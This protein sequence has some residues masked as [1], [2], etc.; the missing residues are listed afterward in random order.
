MGQFFELM[1][2]SIGRIDRDDVRAKLVELGLN[3]EERRGS[4]DW[5]S[6]IHKGKSTRL[7]AAT[8]HGIWN[9]YF[10]RL[11]F[12]SNLLRGLGSIDKKRD[13]VDDF[14]AFGRNL[15]SV[16][17]FYEGELSPEEEGSLLYGLKEKETEQ[18]RKILPANN[19][20]RFLGPDAVHL[21][22]IQD[23]AGKDH[24]LASIQS[25]PDGGSLVIWDASREGLARFLFDEFSAGVRGVNL[26]ANPD[27]SP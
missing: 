22:K 24:P 6:W 25:L 12:D 3:V 9:A 27:E 26:Y 17:P 16:F 10:V 19:Y 14:L 8:Y 18:L 2:L 15:W 5:M 20:A 23:W 4:L 11:G 7:S 13:L 21:A 1:F